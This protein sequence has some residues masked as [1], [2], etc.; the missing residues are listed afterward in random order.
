MPQYTANMKSSPKGNPQAERQ[1]T[2]T[3]TE[4]DFDENIKYMADKYAENQEKERKMKEKMFE[5]GSPKIEGG[6]VRTI[7][8]GGAMSGALRNYAMNRTDQPAAKKERYSSPGRILSAEDGGPA[9]I[10]HEGQMLRESGENKLKGYWYKLRNKDLYYYKKSSDQKEKGLYALSNVFIR[11]EQPEPYDDTSSVYSFTLIFPNKERRFYSLDQKEH[12]TWIEKIKQAIGYQ[13]ITDHYELKESIGKGKFGRVKLGIH[14]ATNKKVAIKILKKK[15]MD[16]EDF[17]LYKREVEILKICQHPNIIRLL[18]VFENFEY[19]FIVMEHL[20]GGSLLQY[21]KDRDYKLPEERVRHITH[22]IGTALF[23]LKNFGIAHRDL[24][25]D[26]MMMTTDDDSSEVKIIDFGLSKI[27]GPNERSKDPFGTIPY[28]APEIILRKPYGHSV[29]IWSLGVTLFFLTTGFHP[30]DSDDQQDLLKKIVRE[31]PD[32]AHE[33]WKDFAPEVQDLVKRLLTKD[34]DDRIV[35]QK[36][37]EHPWITQG[38]SAI[39]KA[40]RKSK[41]FLDQFKQFSLTEGHE[42]SKE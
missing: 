29:D 36:V 10:Y 19:I 7:Q 11:E 35:I 16:P 8:D 39:F 1:D 42:E 3:F 2:D 25:P 23:Y 15:K 17:E 34:R 24:K 9:E 27:I 18:D 6:A 28:A 20:Q 30:F 21:F 13:D 37:L 26:N 5:P 14:K 31:E 41:D 22:Q 4:L 33:R 32:Y 12:A 40:R 38:D